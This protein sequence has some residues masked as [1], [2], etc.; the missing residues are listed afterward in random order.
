MDWNNGTA[1]KTAAL[2]TLIM[3]S[4]KDLQST[5]SCGLFCLLLFDELQQVGGP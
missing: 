4:Y 3:L 2:T 5:R 1:K